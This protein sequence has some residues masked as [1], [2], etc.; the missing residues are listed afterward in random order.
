[1]YQY[2]RSESF[3][4]LIQM[5]P[6]ATPGNPREPAERFDAESVR[7]EWDEAS[8]SYSGRQERGEDFYR[9]EFFGPEM[10]K[11]CGDVDGLSVLDLGCG[12]GYFSREMAKRGAERVLGIDISP[13]QIEHAKRLE[14]RD[15]CGIEYQ[16]QDVTDAVF[17]L[18]A[19]SFDLVT[20][21][22]SLQ[23]MP[24]PERVIQGSSRVLK[25]GGRFV[26]T[27]CHPVT[28]T[29]H[30]EWVRDEDGR[31]LALKIAGYYDPTPFRITWLS[32][33]LGYPFATT[34]MHATLSQWMRWV[35]GAGF[36]IIDVVEPY[37]S[38]EALESRPE[39]D[40]TRIVPTFLQ[41]VAE[42]S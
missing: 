42:K 4:T 23:D 14:K 15:V 20:A 21:C 26:F 41:V 36:R 27:I 40:D 7:E 18:P 17:E 19:A 9:Y 12:S 31:K 16:V 13:R 3:S 37:A 22:V 30:R 25:P 1:M 33:R 32:N 10:V 28:D 29:I 39:L 34:M 2:N 35:I 24:D 8:D 38:D 6:Q 5:I 11:A